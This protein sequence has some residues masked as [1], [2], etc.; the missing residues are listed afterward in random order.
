MVYLHFTEGIYGHFALLT[1]NI[2][3]L[4]IGFQLITF[5]FLADMSGD[6]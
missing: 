5:A 4:S 1:L 6:R 2:V 3:I